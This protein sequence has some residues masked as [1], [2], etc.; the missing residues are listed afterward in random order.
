M[1]NL[2]LWS[3][4]TALCLLA[5]ACDGS[6]PVESEIR[7]VMT[8]TAARQQLA[9]TGVQTGEIT[10]RSE[11]DL[12]FRISGRLISR[13][14]EVGD[15]VQK[16]QVVGRLDDQDAQSS[17]RA[18]R[19]SVR[20]AEASLANAQADEARQHIL[21]AKSIIAP[22]R[23]E[24]ADRD[25]AVAQADLEEALANLSSAESEVAYTELVA[26]SDGIVTAIGADAGEVV[27][28]GTMVVRIAS[29]TEREALF[30]IAE[31]MIR[32]APGK[33]EVEVALA[34]DPAIKAIGTIREIAPAA[35]A[36]TRTYAVRV[37][38]RNPP[39]EMRLGST[40][41]GR[42]RLPLEKLFVVPA[43]ALS[44]TGGRPAVF[45]VLPSRVLELRPV[46]VARYEED[47]IAIS[48]GLAEGERVVSA[49]VNQLRPGQTVRVAREEQTALLAGEA[50]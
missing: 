13:T 31:N 34:D 27:N 17:L 10:P 48:D 33:A 11:T 18:A 42:L 25:L 39:D 46:H 14:V 21:L 22:A 44:E 43:Q 41:T 19:A 20:S 30:D 28:A 8:V 3:G 50:L 40:V 16:G 35:D 23:Y 45:V 12:S 49:G 29:S 2:I 7:P 15:F 26:D 38:L 32:R 24:Q 47:E 1:R 6:S 37:S 5:G 9:D 36:V 4:V